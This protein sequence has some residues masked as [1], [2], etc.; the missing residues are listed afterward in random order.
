MAAWAAD[1]GIVKLQAS[2]DAGNAP[3]QAVNAHFGYEPEYRLVLMRRAIA[4]A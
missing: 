4:S 2:N 3:M 1:N